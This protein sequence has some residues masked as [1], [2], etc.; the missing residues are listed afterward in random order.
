LELFAD[1]PAVVPLLRF[2]EL[3][4]QLST[5]GHRLAS[6]RHPVTGRLHPSFKI[7]GASSGRLSVE[8]PNVQNP[9][10]GP[11]FRALFIP[12]PGHVMIGADYSQI[13]L[14]VAALLSKDRNMLGAYERG[15]DLHR[16]TAASVAGVAP[17]DVTPEQ[18]TAAKAVNFGNLYGQGPD[19]LAKTARLK[20]GVEMTR[21]EAA[22]ALHRFHA[23]YPDL[24]AWKRQQAAWALQFRGY[25]RGWAWSGT[26]T[27]RVR[28][29]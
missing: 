26:S 3:E 29:I 16:L 11:T 5:Y 14:R 15:E 17:A 7:G 1:L 27:C 4:K 24:A 8:K 13:E 20:Y 12:P 6:R 2:K 9:P 18:R 22:N 25:P 10:R 21:E 23:A 28:A 19:G